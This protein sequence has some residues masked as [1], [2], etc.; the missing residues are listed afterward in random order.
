M[1][2]KYLTHY[3]YLEKASEI[4]KGA[5][6]SSHLLIHAQAAM[7]VSKATLYIQSQ[8]GW[9]PETSNAALHVCQA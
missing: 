7:Y 8:D 6:I 3:A 1:M 4:D 9:V 5:N 2:Q